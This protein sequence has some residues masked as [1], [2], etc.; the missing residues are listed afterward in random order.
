MQ[1]DELLNPNELKLSYIQAVCSF[2]LSYTSLFFTRHLFDRVQLCVFFGRLLH[3]SEVRTCHRILFKIVFENIEFGN[4][5]ISQAVRNSNWLFVCVLPNE[6]NKKCA[7][8]QKNCTIFMSFNFVTTIN[9]VLPRLLY[10]IA[11]LNCGR[12]STRLTFNIRYYSGKSETVSLR[13]SNK[14]ILIQK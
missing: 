8:E 12:S 10:A 13:K 5:T 1:E 6:G 7:I 9:S 4:W 14:F 11:L 3:I 2:G